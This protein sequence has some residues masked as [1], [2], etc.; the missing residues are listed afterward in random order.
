MTLHC[1]PSPLTF[2]PFCAFGSGDPLILS[3]SFF[4]PA[5]AC[6]VRLRLLSAIFALRALFWRS[7]P[8]GARPAATSSARRAF[9]SSIGFRTSTSLCRVQCREENFVVQELGAKYSNWGGRRGL[10]MEWGRQRY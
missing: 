5:Y 6:L 3:D 8:R 10:S 1:A 4:S 7:R 2:H 9:A